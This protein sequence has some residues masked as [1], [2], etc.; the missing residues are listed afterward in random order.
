M[1]KPFA[2]LVDG[3][4]DLT[5][6]ECEAR[7]IVMV[8]SH[9]I[10]AGGDEF[11][12]H[13]RWDVI[14][15]ED[16]YAALRRDPGAYTTSPANA[17]EFRAAM[18]PLIR[19]GRSVICI[20][21]ST[22]ISGTLDFMTQAVRE[23]RET[24]PGADIRLVDSLRYSIALG[25]LALKAADL[26][27]AGKSV[28]ETCR[29]IEEIKSTLHQAGWLDD[30]SFVAKKGRLTHAKA[31]FGSMAGVKP[32]GEFDY[33]GLTTV[34]GKARGQK[35][36]YAALLTYIEKTGVALQDQDVVIA[37]TN[38]LPQAEA[39]R[40]MIAER[41]HPRSVRIVDVFPP[42]GINIGPGLMA[43]YYYGAP[44]S[45]GLERE[46]AI[47]TQALEAK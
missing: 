21:I 39:Y 27:D 46:R 2:I 26:R 30:L 31:F 28:D 1:G 35:Q 4:C 34:I 23:I 41:F 42:C 7:N 22:G 20:A 37:Q 14:S 11:L 47:L 16:F 18:E 5:M 12:C 40:D 19:E 3:A 44:I 38:R 13:N 8:P 36:A 6:E 17:E 9:V 45:E 29:E 33:N 10:C 25:M 43:A 24:W 15:K 32:I